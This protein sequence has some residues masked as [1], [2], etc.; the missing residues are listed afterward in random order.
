MRCVIFRP[1][2]IIPLIFKLPTLERVD[3][4]SVGGRPI[5]RTSPKSETRLSFSSLSVNLLPLMMFRR[6][7]YDESLLIRQSLVATILAPEKPLTMTSGRI[8]HREH[9]DPADMVGCG[10]AFGCWL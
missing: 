1:N 2:R 10:D 7:E 3:S 4:Y 6:I 5:G 8:Y 9:D